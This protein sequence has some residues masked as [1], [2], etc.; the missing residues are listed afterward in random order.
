MQ[1]A[2]VIVLAAVLFIAAN[3][4]TFPIW[5][6]LVGCA[7]ACIRARSWVRVVAGEYAIRTLVAA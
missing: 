6:Y 1:I 3:H 4:Y 7:Y 2:A 5:R